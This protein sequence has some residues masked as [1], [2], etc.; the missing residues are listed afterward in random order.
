MTTT[1]SRTPFDWHAIDEEVIEHLRN[2]LRLDTRNPPGNEILAVNYLRSVLEQEGFECT[3]VGPVPERS[4]LITRLKG[5][6]SEPPL[7]LMSH[8]DVVAVEPEKWSH[9]PFG[10]VIEND[11]LYGRGALDMKNMVAMEEMVQQSSQ[12]G[13]RISLPP[14]RKRGICPPKAHRIDAKERRPAM[15]LLSVYFLRIF[16]A[17]SFQARRNSSNVNK[18]LR[19]PAR[20]ICMSRITSPSVMCSSMLYYD[21]GRWSER[22]KS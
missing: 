13:D 5:D 3:V 1:N 14:R 20:Y 4:S 18:P 16:S 19:Y 7:L 8:T 22:P 15:S 12:K 6:G 9:D 2:L 21:R 10:A 11:F 17:M